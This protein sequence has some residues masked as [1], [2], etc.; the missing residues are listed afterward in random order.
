MENQIKLKCIQFPCVWTNI[1]QKW[2]END[3]KSI[4]IT[5]G[6]RTDW[7]I[8]PLSDY[9]KDSAPVLLFKPRHTNFILQSKVKVDFLSMYDAGVLQIRLGKRLW[10][11]LC[12]EYSPQKHPMI[13][14]V[15]TRGVSDDCNSVEI[16]GNEVYLRIYY[17]QQAI[18]FHYSVDGIYWNLVRIFSLKSKNKPKVGLSAQ[19]P[20]GINCKVKFSNIIY[21]ARKIDNLRNGK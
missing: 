3:D 7:F 16:D 15:V 6:K 19:A 12:F 8:D 2:Q 4:E 11:K 20:T 14:S 21:K 13:V 1:P 9:S 10:G 18:A 17:S 5:A